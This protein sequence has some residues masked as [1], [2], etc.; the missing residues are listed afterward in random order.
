LAQRIVETQVK[1]EVGFSSNSII[2]FAAEAA[3]NH[4]RTVFMLLR[5]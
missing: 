5:F 2:C 4:G 3:V 1:P